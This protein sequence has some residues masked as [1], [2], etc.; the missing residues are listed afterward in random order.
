MK[1][2]LAFILSACS[3]CAA[4]PQ[5]DTGSAK[6]DDLSKQMQQL[7]LEIKKMNALQTMAPTDSIGK[8]D[9]RVVQITMRYPLNRWEWILVFSPLLLIAGGVIWLISLLRK[10]KAFLGIALSDKQPEIAEAFNRMNIMRAESA[11]ETVTPAS[12]SRLVMF[13]SGMAAILLS[14][15][16]VSFYIYNYLHTGAAPKMEEMTYILLAL[17]IGVIP[18][19]VNKIKG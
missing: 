6:P 19:A 3:L 16:L 17:G 8:P 4:Y 7:Q 15:V 9:V 10:D 5:S 18:Y 13:L 11:S 2:I 14:A 1:T 12:G